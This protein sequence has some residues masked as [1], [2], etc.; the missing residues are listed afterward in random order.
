MLSP[1]ERD[2]AVE[3]LATLLLEAGGVV[4]PEIDDDRP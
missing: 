3:L 4:A 2:D 1:D